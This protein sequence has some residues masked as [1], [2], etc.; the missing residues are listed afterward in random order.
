MFC[1]ITLSSH[2]SAVNTAALKQ[3][4]ATF[5]ADAY[6]YIF[7]PSEWEDPENELDFFACGTL[8]PIT[9]GEVCLNPPPQF[10]SADEIKFDCVCTTTVD[11]Q[12]IMDNQK[13]GL[14]GFYRA[15]QRSSKEAVAWLRETLEDAD[16][17]FEVVTMEDFYLK[18]KALFRKYK[19]PDPDVSYHLRYLQS[20]Q[21]GGQS[22]E[23]ADA[24][25][26]EDM[27]FRR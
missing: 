2:I 6:G 21:A 13:I 24:K 4:C 10:I 19:V 11:F 23:K 3:D 15:K 7:K 8:I 1:R 16:S 22:E 26:W 5:C 25:Y 18:I 20:R 14:T 17:E 27:S 9:R 12:K